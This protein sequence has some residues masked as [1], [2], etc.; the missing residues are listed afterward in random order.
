MKSDRGWFLLLPFVHVCADRGNDNWL[1]RYEKAQSGTIKDAS[2][3]ASNG[4]AKENKSDG[5]VGEGDDDDDDEVCVCLVD[6]DGF[7]CLSVC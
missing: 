2:L 5:D 7:T 6:T 3:S 1:I 4:T